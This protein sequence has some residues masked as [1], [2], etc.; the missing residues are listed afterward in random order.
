MFFMRSARELW[1]VLYWVGV[2]GLEAPIPVEM[3]VRAALQRHVAQRR[4]ES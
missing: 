3:L 2:T 1:L 4:G